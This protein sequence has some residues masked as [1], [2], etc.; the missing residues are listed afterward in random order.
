MDH[1]G[2]SAGE[3]LTSTI[4]RS[5][6]SMYSSLHCVCTSGITTIKRVQ[7]LEESANYLLGQCVLSMWGSSSRSPVSS[8]NE[9]T[10]DSTQTNTLR[11]RNVK[12]GT[13]SSTSIHT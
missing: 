12:S 7:L 1:S 10:Q 11:K 13:Y 2:H 5:L 4:S 9:F 6:D 3:R 8:S